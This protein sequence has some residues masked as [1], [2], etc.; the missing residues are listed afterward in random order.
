LDSAYRTWQRRKDRY[1]NPTK[2]RNAEQTQP[3]HLNPI[4]LRL[5]ELD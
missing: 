1:L 3:V 2:V 4:Q 5:Y